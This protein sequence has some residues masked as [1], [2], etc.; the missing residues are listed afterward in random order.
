[1]WIVH[2]KAV[3][4]FQ[5]CELVAFSPTV[6]YLPCCNMIIFIL[7]RCIKSCLEFWCSSSLPWIRAHSFY[8]LY[9]LYN[10]YCCWCNI[11]ILWCA[12]VIQE[13]FQLECHVCNT[14]L[15]LLSFKFL[16]TDLLY[17]FRNWLLQ[18]VKTQTHS[19]PVQWPYG[20]IWFSYLYL[21]R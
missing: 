20:M 14:I 9:I 16:D 5:S 18:P 12:F 3:C 10:T 1:M 19:P 2:L 15:S 4:T 7:M 17:L 11:F 21:N 6:P 8:I 13:T